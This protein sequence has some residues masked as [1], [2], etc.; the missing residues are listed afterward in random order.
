M[1]M[2]TLMENTAKPNSH[3]IAKHG[4]SLYLEV[5]NYKILF[6]TGPDASFLENAQRL[7]VDLGAVDLLVLSH[8]HYDHGGGLEDFFQVNHKASVFLSAYVKG[9]YFAQ[10]SET[11]F[12][13]IGLNPVILERYTDRFR[14]V[15]QSTEVFEVL[16]GI[17][18]LKPTVHS[19][20]V[21]SAPLFEKKERIYVQD[22]FAHE[23][24]FVI[25]EKGA[26]HIF[27]GCS[28]NGIINMVL[29]V[30]KVFPKLA[31]R[32]LVG[33]FHLMNTKTNRMAE[34]A[35]TVKQIARMLAE[36]Q[37]GQIY[38]GHCTGAEAFEVLKKIL[39]DTL[40]TLYTGQVVT[41]E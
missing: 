37:I 35:D 28:H 30:R 14:Y 31:I 25:E 4:L 23:L 36:L 10:R 16:P 20:F 8:A 18:L 7:G 19:T 34:T 2:V 40:E 12:Q 21:P 24:I 15:D 5:E 3:L 39:G 17:I 38:T 1:K 32:T 26:L 11:E 41:R 33:G 27:T 13:Y 6:D 9:E 29:S 22:S